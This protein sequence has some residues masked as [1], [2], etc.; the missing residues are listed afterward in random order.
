MSAMAGVFSRRGAARDPGEVER[1]LSMMAS[2]GPD[3]TH[4]WAHDTITLGHGALHAT[5]ESVGEVMPLV[6]RTTG[7]VIVADVRLDNRGELID[8]LR[9]GGPADQL[10]DG[11]LLLDAYREWGEDC[12]DHLLGDFAF[13][14]W[15]ERRRRLFLARDHFGAK[16]LTYHCSEHLFAFASDS[17]FVVGLEGVHRT[18]NRDRVF[19]FLVASTEWIDTTS[20]LFAAVHRL[21]PAHTFTITATEQRLRRYWHLPEPDMLRLRSNE[22]YEEATRA[23]LDQAVRSRL[24]GQADVGV[25]LSGGI[26]S[27]SIAATARIEGRVRS[28][29]AV[30]ERDDTTETAFIRATAAKLHLDASYVT[31]SQVRD[32]VGDFTSV[33]RG[34][35]SLFDNGALVRAV[36]GAARRDGCRSVVSGVLADE[37]VAIPA[38]LA[39]RSFLADRQGS[40]VVR[41]AVSRGNLATDAGRLGLSRSAV[42]V[43]LTRS[44]RVE[45]VLRGRRARQRNE[46]LR[47]SLR[48][49]IL[50]ATDEE[51][52][53]LI[54]RLDAITA[55]SAPGDTPWSTR[56]RLFDGGYSAAA[57]ERYDRAAADCSLESRCPFMDRR[58]VEFFQS[59]PADQLVSG[60]WSKSILR[61]SMAYQLPTPIVWNREKPHLGPQFTEAWVD[62]DPTE[63]LRD[64][65]L[66]HPVGEF[67]DGAELLARADD[68]PEDSEEWRLRS[69]GLGLWLEATATG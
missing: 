65:V 17:R 7:N 28:Y 63:F 56:H 2:R 61:R 46:R 44:V 21:P 18:I 62:R 29:S 52:T 45:H 38:S 40:Q 4:T 49:R 9:L 25:V 41:L 33:Q 51:R 13:V 5:P 6:D 67:V 68:D 3:G 16:P 30:S 26:D 66:G 64:L 58:L 55:R 47:R 31:P 60:G 14:I 8:A 15:D 43:L 57:L 34:N 53:R 54:T 22:E 23:V 12:V 37:V 32:V 11:R 39:M 35:E 42:S 1:M 10:G 69:M 27:S 19:D 59:L 48:G 36:F 50:R 20:T 24:R